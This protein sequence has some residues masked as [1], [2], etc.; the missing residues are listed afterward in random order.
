MRIAD[1]INKADGLKE[2]AFL[3]R[4]QLIRTKPN[5]LKEMISINLLKALEPN[6]RS[7]TGDAIFVPGTSVADPYSVMQSLVA[8]SK[9]KGI[10]IFCSVPS[11][12][13]EIK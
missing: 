1:L 3:G 11:I 2:D 10:K 13:V 6:V 4:A 7:A 9:K 8:L 12:I 5:L